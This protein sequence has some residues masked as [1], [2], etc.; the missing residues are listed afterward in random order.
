V[1]SPDKDGG[2]PHSICHNRKPHVALNFM[3][4]SSTEPELLP[5]KV[6]HCGNRDFCPFM[7]L[8]AWHWS[9]DLYIRTWSICPQDLLKN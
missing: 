5:I 7:F 3:A 8:W 4:L 6:L 9:D 1:Q 2:S